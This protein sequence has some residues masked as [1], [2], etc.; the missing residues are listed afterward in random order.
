MSDTVVIVTSYVSTDCLHLLKQR[1]KISEQNFSSHK[2]D[3]QSVTVGMSKLDCTGLILINIRVK[4]NEICY[5]GLLL[6]HVSGL[7]QVHRQCPSVQIMI[8]F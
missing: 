3:V 7:R 8:V 4:I 5:C 1:R 6:P 2:N